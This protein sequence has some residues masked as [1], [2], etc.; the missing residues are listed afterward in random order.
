MQMQP[1]KRNSTSGIG[2]LDLV[3]CDNVAEDFYNT[4]RGLC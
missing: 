4:L 1:R 2:L 3:R